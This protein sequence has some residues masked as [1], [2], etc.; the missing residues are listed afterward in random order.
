[1]RV[2]LTYLILTKYHICRNVTQD[3][4]LFPEDL[5]TKAQ[6]KQGAVVLHVLGIMYMFYALALVCDDF[7][8]PALDVITE[9]VIMPKGKCKKGF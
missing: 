5:F 7:F 6:L 1:M 3:D 2:I 9:K 8:V 4:P